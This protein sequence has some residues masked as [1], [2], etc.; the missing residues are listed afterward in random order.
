[1]SIYYVKTN[2]VYVPLVSVTSNNA[3]GAQTQSRTLVIEADYFEFD[4]QG[5][6]AFYKKNEVAK[7]AGILVSLVN[8]R[9]VLAVLEEDAYQADYI[10]NPDD[11]TEAGEK[12]D[13]DETCLDCKLENFVKSPTF[14]DEVSS[15]IEYYKTVDAPCDDPDTGACDCDP[16]TCPY[17]SPPAPAEPYPI[18]HWQDKDGKEWWGFFTEKGFVHFNDKTWADDGRERQIKEPD[19]YWG[20]CDLT[21]G[22]RLD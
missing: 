8:S 6:Y 22:K 1:M 14:F 12:D 13:N 21:G 5:S 11:G 19:E 20:Y 16:G 18:E 9:D 4:G 10:F 2:A 3:L 15:I 7:K 17:D